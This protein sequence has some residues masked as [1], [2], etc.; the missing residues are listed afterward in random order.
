M[1][2]RSR[3]SLLQPVIVSELVRTKLERHWPLLAALAILALVAAWVLRRC[4]SFTGGHLVYA[5][6]DPYI[7]MAVARNLVQAGVWGIS[8]AHFASACS[9]LLWPLVLAVCYRLFGVGE[10]LPLLLNLGF[11]VGLLTVSELVARRFGVGARLRF[12]MLAAIVLLMPIFPVA[13]CGLE[14]LLH[15]MLSVA[16]MAASVR[17]LGANGTRRLDWLV[18]GLAALVSMSRYEGLFLVGGAALLAAHAR[19]GRFALSILA[20]AGLPVLAFGLYSLHQGWHFLPNSVLLKG[21]R[22]E[23]TPSSLLGFAGLT[24]YRELAQNPHLLVLLLAGMGMLRAVWPARDEQ[25]SA[26]RGM[27]L[28][29]AVATL[30]QLNFARTGWFYRYEAYLVAMWLVA[31]FCALPLAR[32][33]DVSGTRLLR[34]AWPAALLVLATCPLVERSAEAHGRTARASHEIYEQ[35]FQ[36]ARLLQ[37]FGSS[38]VAANDIG[39]M[40]YLAAVEVIDLYGLATLEVGNAKL[41]KSYG[42]PFIDSFTH[43]KRAKL[44]IVYDP[45][46]EQYGGL[47]RS[48]VKVGEWTIQENVIVGG[49]TVSFYVIDP[50]F[51]ATLVF[52]LRAFSSQLPREVE[53]RGAYLGSVPSPCH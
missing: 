36:M 7:S 32:R 50:S 24:G 19:R 2:A 43:D 51:C 20:S 29:C 17:A 47:P 39:A 41:G 6:D 30:A 5:L 28:L 16:F 53:Q 26:A 37:R 10:A 38:V 4:F 23:L 13:M 18:L 3:R 25:A 15:A 31:L 44:A 21:Q 8:P 49:R 33:P 34:L 12:S 14:H 45:W 27:L 40:S 9:S 42:L 46:F 1:G 11:S 52:G 48:W 22:L 35:Q